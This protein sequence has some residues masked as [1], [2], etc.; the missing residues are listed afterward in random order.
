VALGLSSERPRTVRLLALSLLPAAIHLLLRHWHYGDWLPNTYYLKI[1][2]IEDRTL[3]GIRY[4][5][6]FVE[7]YGVAL[8]LAVVG[9]YLARDRRRWLLL[10]PVPLAGSYAFL[11]G[12]DTF[13]YARFFAHAVPL[14]LV[15]AVVGAVDLAQK[16]RG[17]GRAAL[18]LF[19]MTTPA[20]RSF[21]LVFIVCG[22]VLLPA[23]AITRQRLEGGNWSQVS[24]L[25][26]GLTIARHSRPESSVA[27]FAAGT[28]PYFSRRH[29]V[30][31]LGK[32]DRHIA[33]QPTR[34]VGWVGHN[35]FDPDYSFG[36]APDVVAT[37]LFPP[38]V[39]RY[40]GGEYIG[41]FVEGTYLPT[42]LGSAAFREAYFPNLVP[43][44]A[45][46]P[47]T[48]LYVRGSSPELASINSWYEP[49]VTR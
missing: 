5:R 7:S 2:G 28:L 33:R 12:G 35:K 6:R 36:L 3:L 45:A 19:K 9:A 46:P 20:A 16:I 31:L 48:A 34:T 17:D 14:V 38:M 21:V 11:V 18:G 39:A 32:M 27:V 13:P 22:S 26:N 8:A 49:D 15:L 44:T 43:A 41:Q 30:D 29:T 1:V 47:H 24:A 37:H 42:M 23:G 10:A 25:L 4:L 40:V